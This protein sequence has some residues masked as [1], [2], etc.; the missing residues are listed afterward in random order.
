MSEKLK[1]VPGTAYPVPM[2]DW[3]VIEELECHAHVGVPEEERKR[4]QKLLVDLEL[5]LDLRKAGKN[6]R[7]EETVDYASAARE[8]RRFIEAGSFRLVESIAEGAAA[9]VL[10]RFPIKEARVRV[11]KFSV[12]GAR[13]V[14]VS[15]SRGTSR[16]K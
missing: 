1:S 5:G 13:S 14:G 9:L 6:D 4:R 16:T 2:L 11:R 3:V 10:E 7:V 8:V 15:V 12:P